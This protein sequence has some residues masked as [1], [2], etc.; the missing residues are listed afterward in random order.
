MSTMTARDFEARYRR[1]L[2]PW[3]YATSAYERA[4]YAATLQ[5]CGPGPFERAL[6]LGGS[7]GVFS[8][9]LAPRCR[10]L[11]S[12]DFAPTAVELAHAALARFPRAE[13]TSGA[14]PDDMPDGPFDLVVASEILYYLSERRLATTLA[15]L[16][17][18]LASG[19]RLVCVHWIPGGAERPL[20][21]QEVHAVVGRQRWLAH[22]HSASTAD[23]LLDVFSRR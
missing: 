7:I 5:A 23:Y 11:V 19:G 15:K 13:A 22:D 1:E 20:L 14:V 12:L 6:E 18:R 4:K 21:A 9:Q 16:E 17:G 2:D 3:S 8:A 10:R